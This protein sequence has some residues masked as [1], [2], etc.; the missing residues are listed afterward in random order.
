MIRPGPSGGVQQGETGSRQPVATADQDRMNPLRVLPLLA[1]LVLPA[2]L[3]MEQTVVLD[4]NGGGRQSLRLTLREAT[5]AEVQRASAAAQLGG[6]LNPAALFDKQLAETELREVGFTL[7]SHEAK[8]VPGKRSVALEAAFPDF[9]TLQKSPFCGT[10]AE[11]VLAAGP[12]AG[13]A[14]L[15]LYPQGKAAWIEAAK[16]AEQLQASTDPVAAEFFRKRQLQ[17]AGLDVKVRFLLPGDVHLWTKNMEK[18][19][20]R[21]VTATITAEQIQTPEDLV[22]RL[23]PR[24]E[25]V[26]DAKDCKFGL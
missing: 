22:R 9:A 19:G 16:K 7:V 21:E 5:I 10:A 1:L 25:V 13:T 15:T 17:L 14:K 23:A 11:W 18:T 8:K 20:P 6:A 26:F 24:F 2:C 4:A 12:T 3:E